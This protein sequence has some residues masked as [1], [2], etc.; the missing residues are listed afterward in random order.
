[1]CSYDARKFAGVEVLNV[2]KGHRDTFRYP[3]E[4]TLA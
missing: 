3:L 1:M 4:K 2:L